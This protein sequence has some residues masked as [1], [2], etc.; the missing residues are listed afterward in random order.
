F[1]IKLADVSNPSRIWP[2]YRAWFHLIIQEFYQ[3][4]DL[5]RS[6]KYPIAP[7][8]NRKLMTMPKIQ[9]GFIKFLAGPLFENWHNYCKSNFSK[10]LVDT[11]NR[12]SL[13]LRNM[14]E[15]CDRMLVKVE[16]YIV[17]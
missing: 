5:E 12:N 8:M 1:V 6:F 17:E 7:T 11:V 10:L 2:I 9:L 15:T 4:G 16:N 3:Q 14:K 13:K